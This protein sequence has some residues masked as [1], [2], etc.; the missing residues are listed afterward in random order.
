MEDVSGMKGEAW[1]RGLGGPMCLGFLGRRP[2]TSAEV[3]VS[4]ANEDPGS[5]S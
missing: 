4:L 5:V 3:Q 2:R 1:E